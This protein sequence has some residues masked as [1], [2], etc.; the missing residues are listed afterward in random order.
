MLLLPTRMVS[1]PSLPPDFPDSEAA[2]LRRDWMYTQA[3]R[4]R[5]KGIGQQRP[6]ALRLQ[7]SSCSEHWAVLREFVL[8]QK[9]EFFVRTLEGTT[10]RGSVREPLVEDVPLRKIRF[11]QSSV[12]PAVRCGPTIENLAIAMQSTG[13]NHEAA[14]PNAVRWPNG[15][16]TT[17]D[18]RRI[19]AAKLAGLQSVPYAV[20]APADPVDAGVSVQLEAEIS[21]ERRAYHSSRVSASHSIA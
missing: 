5:A 1:R 15:F 3:A 14:P 19:V 2:A 10:P 9:S 20:H 6:P 13:W 7:R 4:G 17:F 18:H 12:Y 21:A 16:L 8:Y 11:S